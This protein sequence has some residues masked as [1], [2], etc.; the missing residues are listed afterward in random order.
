MQPLLRFFQI[1]EDP[2]LDPRIVVEHL[3]HPREAE[4]NR[5]I[6]DQRRL[7]RRSNLAFRAPLRHREDL[8]EPYVD[9]IE[10]RQIRDPVAHH[11][12]VLQP[13]D[14]ARHGVQLRSIQEPGQARVVVLAFVANLERHGQGLERHAPAGSSSSLLPLIQAVSTAGVTARPKRHKKG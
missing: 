2:D 5:A 4:L 14:L 7:D 3:E 10:R 13:F 11:P 6:R 12:G 8:F 1:A 9:A